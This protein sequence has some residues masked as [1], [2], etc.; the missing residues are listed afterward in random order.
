MAM[1]DKIE[2]RE[3]RTIDI[4]GQIFKT[5]SN[6]WIP[7]KLYYNSGLKDEPWHSKQKRQHYY[8][9][10]LIKVFWAKKRSK[11]KNKNL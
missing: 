3:E 5:T 10:Q 8:T 1:K 11:M 2:G 9:L 6:L 7:R 4:N